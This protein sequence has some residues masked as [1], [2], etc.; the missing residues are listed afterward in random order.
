MMTFNRSEILRRLESHFKLIVVRHP[1]DRFVSGYLEKFR[2]H[3]K[4]Y[5]EHAGVRIIKQFRQKPSNYSLTHG[6]DVTFEE[7][8]RYVVYEQES[9]EFAD[10]HW[11]N[12]EKLCFPCAIGYDY[13][14][15]LE[16][17]RKDSEYV[18]DTLLEGVRYDK[19]PVKNQNRVR[20]N[21]EWGRG[22]NLEL[23]SN[24]TDSLFDNL[25]QF[26]GEDMTMFGYLV[27][28]NNRTIVKC[29][30]GDECC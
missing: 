21:R 18:I 14:A 16:T 9:R 23:F 3:K 24:I 11:E 15:K 26:Y 29:Q 4:Y 13:I 30:S 2:G 12:Y 6:D 19:H 20:T 1:L 22:E 17:N 27:D 5:K 8:M 7:F 10:N 28:R 25:L